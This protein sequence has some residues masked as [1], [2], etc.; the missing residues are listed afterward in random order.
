MTQTMRA[1]VVDIPGG[2]EVMHLR[3]VPIP[4]MRPTDLLIRVESCG[5]CFHDVVTRNG[6]LRRGIKMPVIPG[7]EVSGIVEK[8]GPYVFGFK[9][10]DRVTTTQRRHICGH[11]TYC[12]SS[13][14]TS[15]NDR[16]FLGDIGL[17][18][19][20]AE[21]VAVQ[22]D[23][24]CHIPQ[25]VSFNQAAITS[26]AI[27][28]ELNAVRDVGKVKMGEKVL[29]TGAGGG[30]GVHGIQLA[31]LAGAYVIA[32]TSSK[33]KQKIILENGAHE[34]LLVER[35]ED[36][37]GA[38][39]EATGGNGVDVVI[40]NVGSPTFEATRRSLA[41]GARWIFVGQVTGDFV[42]LN[43]AQLFMRDISIMSAKSTSKRQLQDA[44]D[45]VA[46]GD[47]KPV[48]T[49]EMSLEHAAKAHS[50]V[51]AGRSTGRIILKPRL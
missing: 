46:R 14:E 1:V 8:I 13:R 47:I 45:L 26:C 11:C 35:G 31:R 29:V 43:P 7:H 28:T 18:G 24:V 48:I 17:N 50:D 5:V 37:S 12:R 15:C 34:V 42:K 4:E 40:D 39:K 27:G 22:Q 21:F 25:G 16:E 51:E 6:V 44:L 38:V 20:Y 49:G 19:G 3:E 41:M 2:P 30:L 33:E 36:F 32:V 23:G 10:G 9:P